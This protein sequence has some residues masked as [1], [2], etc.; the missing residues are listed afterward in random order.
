M[1]LDAGVTRHSSYKVR[2]EPLAGGAIVAELGTNCYD[3]RMVGSNLY[4][5]IYIDRLI[6]GVVYNT[7]MGY[8][9]PICTDL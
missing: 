2:Q 9:A 8:I 1:G 5:Y 4:I 6:S 3:S 7:I